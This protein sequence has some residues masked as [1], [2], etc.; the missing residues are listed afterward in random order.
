MRPQSISMSQ[1]RPSSLAVN[2]VL[3]NTYFLLSLTLL[4]SAACAG[5]SMMSNAQPVG[6]GGFFLGW[7]GLY[8]L[9]LY[10]RNSA[11][12][13]LAVFAFTG[14]VGYT[15]GPI[16]HM[17]MH[18][19]TNGGQIISTALG[20]TGFIFLSLSAY[21]LTTRKDFSFL[22]GF[23]TIAILTAFLMGIGAMVFQL[24]AMSLFVSGAFV[25]L[26]SAYILYTTSAII[27]GGETNYI[28]AT[29]SL[30]VALFNIFISLL[31]ILGI[32][33]GNRS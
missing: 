18:S 6:I 22:G 25:I 20:A 21:V 3:R 27:H 14:F 23:I 16:L 30:F 28:I 8:F 24:P 15:L 9:T 2:Q 11:W 17:Y 13:L 31:Q 7:F 10:L 19:F 26:C 5:W 33:G 32:F 4:F 1:S 29:V 12:G